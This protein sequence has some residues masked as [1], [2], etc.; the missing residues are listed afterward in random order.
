MW[1]MGRGA[2]GG[3]QGNLTEERGTWADELRAR[4]RNGARESIGI[5]AWLLLSLKFIT[6]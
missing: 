5:G 2:G 4:E 3:A 1:N 6:V